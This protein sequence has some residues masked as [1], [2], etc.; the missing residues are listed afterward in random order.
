MLAARMTKLRSQRDIN[1]WRIPLL[2][3][4]LAVGLFG[5]TMTFDVLDK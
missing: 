5:L 2:M 1:S 3:S 4:G